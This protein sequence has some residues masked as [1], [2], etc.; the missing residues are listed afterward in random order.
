MVGEARRQ[1]PSEGVCVG[2]VASAWTLTVCEK[3]QRC[4][5]TPLQ[6]GLDL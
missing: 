5:V 2:A 6:L 4:E 1:G 3:L